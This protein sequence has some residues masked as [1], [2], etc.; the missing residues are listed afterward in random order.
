M[1]S[2]P[3]LPP[4]PV[5]VPAPG[6]AVR[7]GGGDEVPVDLVQVVGVGVIVVHKLVHEVGGDGGGDPLSGVNTSLQPHIGGAGSSLRLE[8]D[9]CILL[10]F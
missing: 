8:N 5:V 6:V 4:E 9:Y 10:L 3:C 7:V 1:V 2:R